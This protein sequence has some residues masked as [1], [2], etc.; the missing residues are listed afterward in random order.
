LLKPQP[1]SPDNATQLHLAAVQWQASSAAFN[2]VVANFGGTRSQGWLSLCIDGLASAD[3]R[4]SD[5]LGNEVHERSG[6]ELTQRGLYLDLPPHGAQ[7]FHCQR[8]Q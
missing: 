3:W 5:L 4:L 7:L 2:I 6:A 1:A 8:I